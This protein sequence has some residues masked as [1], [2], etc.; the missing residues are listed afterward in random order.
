MFA[1][2]AIADPNLA[3]TRLRVATLDQWAKAGMAMARALVWESAQSLVDA[4]LTLAR[5]AQAVRLALALAMR[6]RDP[7][8][9]A[10]QP[11]RARSR[12][13]EA[14]AH[15]EK[16]R[17]ETDPPEN[18]TRQGGGESG[19][20]EVSDAV[21]LRRP[22]KA[23]V[24]VIC[25]NLGI[26]PDWSLWSDEVEAPRDFQPPPAAPSPAPVPEPPLL[27]GAVLHRLLG[28]RLVWT[29]PSEQTP[30]PARLRARLRSTASPLALTPIAP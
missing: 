20:H 11:T 10:F 16:D 23:I 3:R 22:L 9:W 15:A 7:T 30:A 21:I 2:T 19:E 17:A 26:I 13:V 4:A 24:K 5:I 29:S 18:P 1:A 8:P 14:K 12:A 28:R 27:Q 25:R 6:L